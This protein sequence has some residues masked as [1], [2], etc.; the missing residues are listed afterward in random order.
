MAKHAGNGARSP[1]SLYAI[2]RFAVPAAAFSVVCA[3][4]QQGVAPS[5]DG[6]ARQGRAVAGRCADRAASPFNTLTG[7]MASD[8][9]R[10]GVA[11]AGS[12]RSPGGDAGGRG[13][14]AAKIVAAVRFLAARQPKRVALPFWRAARVREG[15]L[16]YL[17]MDR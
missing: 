17:L 16:V 4:A 2:G 14:F 11:R 7:G 8:R 1:S 15:F 3:K 13:R 10:D 6:A 9:L 5:D 12:G